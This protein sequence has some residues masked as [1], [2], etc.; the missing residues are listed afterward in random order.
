MKRKPYV[1]AV[2]T[3][4]YVVWSLVPVAI[5]VLFSFNSGRSRSTWQGFSLRW[6]WSDPFGSLRND[7][8]LRVALRNSLVL[9]ALTILIATPIG[10][11]LALGLTRWRSRPAKVANG[12]L[13]LPLIT[14]ELVVGTALF[15]VVTN[16]YSF[17]EL[18]RT[19]QLVGHVTFSLTYVVIV[20]RGRL[21]SIGPD[22]EEAARDLGATPLQAIRLVVL[23][24]LTPAIFAAGVLVFATSIDDFVVSALLSSGAATETVPVRIYSA[25]RG[26]AT[27][28]LNALATVM[29]VASMV[30]LILVFAV[31]RLTRRRQGDDNAGENS[32][33]ELASW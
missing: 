18:G 25:T 31:M 19:A 13:L 29:L 5:A 22:V 27:P 33:K 23:P 21:L 12:V 26:G 24:L 4:L 17:L 16:A 7:E 11:G 6:Y 15:L 8:S 28:A 14:P 30:A 32:L 9:A 10:V 3:G 1:L 20:V 2:I